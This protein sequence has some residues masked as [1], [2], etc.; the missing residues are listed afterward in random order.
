LQFTVAYTGTALTI[1][2]MH[3]QS[4]HIHQLSEKLLVAISD[5]A[6]PCEIIYGTNLQLWK[7]EYNK[8]DHW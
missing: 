2:Q 4:L 7:S 5:Y 6:K 3:S 8:D 1:Q